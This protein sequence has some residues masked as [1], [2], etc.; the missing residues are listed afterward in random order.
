MNLSIN[1]TQLDEQSHLQIILLYPGNVMQSILWSLAI[2]SQST[3][4]LTIV[5]SKSLHNKNQFVLATLSSFEII[6]SLSCSAVAI[7]R[8]ILRNLDQP[9][10]NWQPICIL[11]VWPIGISYLQVKIAQL[12]LGIDR[13][14]A[15]SAPIFYKVKLPMFPCILSLNIF[16]WIYGLLHFGLAFTKADSSLWQFCVYGV[17]VPSDIRSSADY[18][19]LT[20]SLFTLLVYIACLLK[21]RNRM[22]LKRSETRHKLEMGTFKTTLILM[23]VDLFFDVLFIILSNVLLP[24]LSPTLQATVMSNLIL[25]ICTNFLLQVPILLFM[26]TTFRCAFMEII[27]RKNANAVVPF[28]G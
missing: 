10:T 19:S 26:S 27:F 14:L 22:R 28:T 24:V 23:T 11:T 5:R 4:L 18:Q 1:W 17:S 21:L 2:F 8:C 13:L 6:H 15:I 20:I 7:H 3:L 25:M 16:C 12:A 9:D